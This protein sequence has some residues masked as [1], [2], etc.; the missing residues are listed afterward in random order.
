MRGERLDNRR[1]IQGKEPVVALLKLKFNSPVFNL[2]RRVCGSNRLIRV[3]RMDTSLPLH[4]SLHSSGK[5]RDPA[6]WCPGENRRLHR[7]L[8][9]QIEH[10][11]NASHNY[12][13]S[14]PTSNRKSHPRVP[15][16]SILRLCN[17]FFCGESN[18]GVGKSVWT[19]RSSSVDSSLSRRVAVSLRIFERSPSLPPPPAAAAARRAAWALKEVKYAVSGLGG[20]G[21]VGFWVGGWREGGV[22]CDV[23]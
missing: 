2:G 11:T 19:V 7:F 13:D 9:P 8:L 12:E 20:M 1:E 10:F 14:S 18:R 21:G 4:Q 23:S 5:K 22:R 3:L 15:A 6:S 16:S 17:F